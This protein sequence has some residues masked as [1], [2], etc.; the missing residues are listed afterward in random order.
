MLPAGC[1][2][3]HPS[4]RSQRA[5]ETLCR[6]TDVLFKF[7]SMQRTLWNLR[8]WS[9]FR[10]RNQAHPKYPKT[11]VLRFPRPCL[12]VQDCSFE[13]EPG[14]LA[15][16]PA[17]HHG[18]GAPKLVLR[19]SDDDLLCSSLSAKSVSGVPISNCV[20]S[21]HRQNQP[22]SPYSEVL[23]AVIVLVDVPDVNCGMFRKTFET[24]QLLLM[25]M[26]GMLLPMNTPEGKM[27]IYAHMHFWKIHFLIS[28]LYEFR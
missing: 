25:R 8:M 23:V 18:H 2:A 11:F 14:R 27:H 24:S 21:A 12:H 4:V 17:L 6:P 9:R 22:S 5:G 20:L 26:C 15:R 13:L 16:L 1:G 19:L 3:G 7:A 28:I 10:F